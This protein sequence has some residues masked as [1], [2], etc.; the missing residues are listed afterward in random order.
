MKP[1]AG[2]TSVGTV[3]GSMTAVPS[4]SKM[5]ARR[6]PAMSESGG[7]ATSC[8]GMELLEGITVSEA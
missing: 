1:P 6:C 8:E 2:A 3:S 5:Q 7:W 4:R